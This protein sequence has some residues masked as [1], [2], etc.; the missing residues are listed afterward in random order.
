MHIYT[1]ISFFAKLAHS[2]IPI[3]GK[4]NDVVGKIIIFA[5]KVGK[6][7]EELKYD[8]NKQISRHFCIQLETFKY[9]KSAIC[10]D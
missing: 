1:F 3:W 10:R 5:N 6:K 7:A 2:I 9:L 4:N 8:Y